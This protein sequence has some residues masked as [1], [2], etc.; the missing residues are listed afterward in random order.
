VVVLREQP[1]VLAR[2]RR[3][4]LRKAWLP[5]PGRVAGICWARSAQM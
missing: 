1:P 5:R 3:T 4:V 2:A